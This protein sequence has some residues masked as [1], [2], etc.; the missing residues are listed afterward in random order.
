[1]PKQHAQLPNRDAVTRN[2]LIDQTDVAV[3]AHLRRGLRASR[4][5]LQ[6]RFGRGVVVRRRITTKGW[7]A[8][9]GG[10]ALIA[11]GIG[12]FLLG[13]FSNIR[14]AGGEPVALMLAGGQAT[15]LG[16]GLYCYQQLL[17]RSTRNEEALL[18]QYDIGYE[19]GHRDAEK[20]PVLVD[21]DARRPCPCG[22]GM[23]DRSA[24]K[25]ID[26]V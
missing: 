10:A 5:Q 3:G 9:T 7:L 6:R 19:A 16:T 20:R 12:L 21:L 26:R 18:F 25:V 17:V 15:I 2:F 24:V 22:S 13:F 4:Y 11:V 14:L 1:M 23:A 8:K